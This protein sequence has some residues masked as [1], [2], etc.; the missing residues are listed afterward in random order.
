MHRVRPETMIDSNSQTDMI[1]ADQSTSMIKQDEGMS[2]QEEVAGDKMVAVHA[3]V[4][5]GEPSLSVD[6]QMTS[7]ENQ[8][9][10]APL[11]SSHGRTNNEKSPV[12]NRSRLHRNSSS[13]SPT[14][15]SNSSSRLKDFLEKEQSQ[16]A[17]LEDQ[18]VR[19]AKGVLPAFKV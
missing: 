2:T 16:Y 18:I 8:I 14:G 17:I 1:V 9:V 7:D 4:E 3:G 15:I 13:N 12:A 11:D 19:V 10:I 6:H 5:G